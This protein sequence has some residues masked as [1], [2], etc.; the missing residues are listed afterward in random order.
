MK[1]KNVLSLFCVIVLFIMPWFFMYIFTKKMKQQSNVDFQSWLFWNKYPTFCI[2]VVSSDRYR[3]CWPGY[4]LN[5]KMPS[6]QCMDPHVKDKMVSR[7]S[8][9]WHG[10]THTTKDRLYV[11]T[12]SAGLLDNGNLCTD[13]TQR[14]SIS[15]CVPMCFLWLS[16]EAPKFTKNK[17]WV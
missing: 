1:R 9:L 11:E 4:R 3:S 7:P 2:F 6:Y 13:L 5:I 17:N 15:S 8:Y 16:P 10:N 14:W 12:G